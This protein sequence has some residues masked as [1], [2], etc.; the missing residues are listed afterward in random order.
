MPN[1]MQQYGK[2]RAYTLGRRK[3]YA[4]RLEHIK[5][6]IHQVAGAQGMVKSCM[7]GTRVYQ[8]SHAHLFDVP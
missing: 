5:G 3:L 7:H 1:I 6:L 2:T 4:L 8:V